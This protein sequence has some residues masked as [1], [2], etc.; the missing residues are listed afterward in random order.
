MLGNRS[1]SRSR[2][3]VARKSWAARSMANMLMFGVERPDLKVAE[4][5]SDGVAVGGEA[6]VAGMDHDGDPRFVDPGP[7][8]IEHLVGGRARP[9][10]GRRARPPA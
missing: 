4:K 6:G 2:I 7:E 5:P 10:V 1:K 3:R 9:A 8:R